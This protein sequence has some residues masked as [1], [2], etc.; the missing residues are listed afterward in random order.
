MD[1]ATQM[2][3]Y[4]GP[5]EVGGVRTRAALALALV[6]GVS[7]AALFAQQGRSPGGSRDVT[8]PV[9]LAIEDDRASTPADLDVLL[10]ALRGPLA[11]RAIQAL[12]RLERRDVITDLLPYLAA[13]TTR[14]VCRGSVG[15]VASRDP[16]STAF[17]MAS[18]SEPC[19]TP[20][21]PPV[22]WSSRVPAPS[23]LTPIT[24]A[25]GRLPYEEV[26]SFRSAETF[27]RKVLERPFPALADEPHIGARAGSRVDGEV[28][29]QD[30][31]AR[32]GDDCAA[33][34]HRAHPRA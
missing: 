21:S 29:A 5:K 23:A 10:S 26:E 32:R 15:T 25:V 7:A 12:G 14:G 17:R 24:R 16:R 27:L 3:E 22:I 33:A 9:I 6:A 2:L 11:G 34:D 8:L 18:R 1:L 13:R 4:S 31:D 30:R 20:C 28:A 19:S